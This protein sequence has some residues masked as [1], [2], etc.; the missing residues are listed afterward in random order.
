VSIGTPLADV[1]PNYA[2]L[3]GIEPEAVADVPIAMVGT[4]D[5]VCAQLEAR[6][7]RWG[8]NYIVVHEADIDPFAPVVER[9][10]GT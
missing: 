1:A 8:F 5:E 9:L 3:L 4:V 2:P 7:A 10:A 6:R